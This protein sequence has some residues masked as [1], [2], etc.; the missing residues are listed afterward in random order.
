MV[1][2]RAKARI[3][4]ESSAGCIG[5]IRRDRTR[6]RSCGAG[7]DNCRHSTLL[8]FHLACHKLRVMDESLRRACLNVAAFAKWMKLLIFDANIDCFL[9]LP[10]TQQNRIPPTLQLGSDMVGART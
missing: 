4:P 6:R 2:A 8:V 3:I 9:L 5:G 10:T 7:R 1:D